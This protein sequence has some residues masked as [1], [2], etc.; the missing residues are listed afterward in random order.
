MPDEKI[1]FFMI[2][3]MAILIN[4]DTVSDDVDDNV[5]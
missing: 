2:V 3:L 1:V 5:G 4:R